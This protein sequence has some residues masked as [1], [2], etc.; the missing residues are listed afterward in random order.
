MDLEADEEAFNYPTPIGGEDLVC[1][2]IS[3]KHKEQ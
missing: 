3:L 2:N 1:V